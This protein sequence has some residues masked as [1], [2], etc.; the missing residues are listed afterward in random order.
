ML[1]WRNF[2]NQL[3][4]QC[5]YAVPMGKQQGKHAINSSEALCSLQ[6]QLI[7]TIHSAGYLLA[8]F[9]MITLGLLLKC[10]RDALIQL[11]TMQLC[12]Y[13]I[14]CNDLS[15]IQPTFI[16]MYGVD[17]IMETPGYLKSVIS[18]LDYQWSLLGIRPEKTPHPLMPTTQSS[19]CT[20]GTYLRNVNACACLIVGQECSHQPFFH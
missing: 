1:L 7:M 12:L 14:T 9:K 20:P 5:I 3:V 4:F 13:C 16:A 10:C 15:V 19:V 17:K 8:Q 2:L 11:W 18:L 6:I